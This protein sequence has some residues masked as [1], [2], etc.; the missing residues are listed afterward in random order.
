MNLTY[1]PYFKRMSSLF[2]YTVKN[3]SKDNLLQITRVYD[4][5]SVDKFLGR[6]L[7]SAFTE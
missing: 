4:A 3:T 5:S 7:P 6:P 1:Y 2:N